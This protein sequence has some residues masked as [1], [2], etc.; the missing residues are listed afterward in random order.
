LGTPAAGNI[1]P[2]R[3]LAA[4]WTGKGGDFWI[5]GGDSSDENGASS[6]ML[7]DLWEFNPSTNEWAWMAGS[8][9]SDQPGSYGT[10]GTPSALNTPGSREDA[11]SWT[12]NKGNLWL[13]GGR[14]TDANGAIDD[15]LLNDLWE[16]SPSTSEWTW[17]SGS[18]TVSSCFNDGSGNLIG[19][20]HCAQAATYGTLGSPATGNT[21]GSREGALTWTDSKG[22]LWLFGGWSFDVPNQVQYY[23]DELWEYST[24]TNQW[25][26]MGGSGTRDGSACAWNVNLWYSS[27]GEPGVYGTLG[28]PASG[29]IPG[30]RS[31]AVSW[32]DTGGNFWLFSGFGFDSIGYIGDP[33]DLWKYSPATNQWTWMGGSSALISPDYPCDPLS[34]GGACSG[35]S[36][37]GAL[38]VPAAGNIPTGRDHAVG[39]N[40]S[41]GNIWLYG[42]GVELVPN[43]TVGW[44]LNDIWEFNPSLNQWALMGGNIESLCGIYCSAS[45]GAVY[46]IL[47]MPAPGNNPGVR[48]SS[49]GWTGGNGNLWLFGGQPLPNGVGSGFEN[50]LWEYQPSSGPLPT[51]APPTFSTPAGSYASA[52]I[53]TI[54]DATNGAFIYYTT[55]GTTPTI[56][57]TVFFSSLSQPISIPYSETLKAIA[58]APG[59][60]DSAVATA[61]YTLPPQAATPTLSLPTGTYTSFQS[62]TISDATPD[63]IIY[64][65]TSGIAP[66]TS[67]S[68]YTGPISDTYAYMPLQAV[69]I[70]DG[71]S[72][73]D[74]ASAAYTLNVSYAYAAAPTFSVICGTYTSA[75]TVSI[76]DTTPSATIFYTT[77]GTAPTTSSPVYNGP[78]TVSSTETIWAMA[79]ATNYYLSDYSDCA[80]TINPQAPQ[81]AAPSFSVVAGTYTSAQT[82]S[83]SDTTP[84]ATI[85][86]TTNGTAPTTSSTVYSGP[87]TVSSSETLEAIATA[88]GYSTSNVATAAYTI[89]T[90]AATPTFSVTTGTYAS[91]QTVTISDTTTGASIYYTADGTTPTTSS[92]QYTGAI[93]VAATETIQAIAV[94]S[95]Y[96]TSAVASATYTINLPAPDFSV[97]GT[98]GSMTVTGGQSATTSISVTPANGF[99]S[100]VSFSCSGLPSGATCS[101]SPAT[102][103]PSGAAA[104]TTVT[105][106]TTTAD[107]ALHGNPRPL[108]PVAALAALLCC[109]GFGKRRRLLV[110]LLVI[111]AAG[112]GLL[113]GCGGSGSGG[114]GGGSQSATYTITV[115][116]TSGSLQH[117]ATFSLTVD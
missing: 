82:V 106:T 5:F 52:Q 2:V 8:T 83:I 38:G 57:S 53:V 34:I 46:G 70:A 66:T 72:I 55:D 6:A 36:V 60:L 41:N 25:T 86:Y 78:I 22:N 24:S 117:T 17:M 113:G 68:V 62:I 28:T 109:F 50:D 42:G 56:N 112:L 107:A 44:G 101:F 98:P 39:W 35:P 100:V 95:G 110:L 14:G 105:V 49:S 18:S 12:D 31:D 11:S 74:V 54:D 108:V 94:A 76:S 84:S 37:F 27:C 33:Q 67:S 91:A 77:N 15:V 90:L 71:Y 88:S 63:A 3:Y 92:T 61:V 30:G 4:A 99:S 116:A 111:G 115:N 69:A 20:I 51:T 104:S 47:A 40:D 80:Y 9:A 48:Y 13:F 16:F 58:I 59:C 19:A 10:M 102:V 45:T 32:T 87:I 79:T 29:D 97:A 7:N 96:S 65:T 73:S 114:G 81:T 64:Y 1:P 93:T 75:Q 21:P 103:T 85:I 26:W 43:S 23:F 89:A